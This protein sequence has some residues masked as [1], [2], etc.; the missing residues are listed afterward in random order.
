MPRRKQVKAPS[1]GRHHRLRVPYLLTAC[2]LVLIL[3][4]ISSTS[5]LAGSAKAVPAVHLQLMDLLVRSYPKFLQG[6]AEGML[7]W[8]D[9]T[10]MPFDDGLA[11]K[12]F[13][14]RLN[15]PDLQ[16]MFYVRYPLGRKGLPPAFRAD[17][18]RVR[19][20][21]FFN[22]MYGDCS[23]WAGPKRRVTI[24][25]LPGK[26]GRRIEVTSVNG[27]AS[28]LRKVSAKLDRLPARF[29]R[30][31]FPVA[32]T[33]NCRVI[34][35]TKRKSV[36]S[37]AAAIDINLKHANYWRWTKPGRGGRYRHR[38]RI[39]WEIVSIFEEHGFIWGGKWYHYDTMH[40]EYRP[41][42]LAAGR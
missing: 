27:V 23:R 8:K 38:N 18:G 12:S 34:A 19:Y 29:N 39:P 42:I 17:P 5:S 6:H 13:Y 31:L 24:V 21:P 33:Y 14:R 41:E 3:A 11:D 37:Y 1:A 10:R 2:S 25:W 36:H 15:S 7:I 9:G 40:F 22:K 32:G 28:Q 16:D 4:A 26:W 20:E 30:F 35:G